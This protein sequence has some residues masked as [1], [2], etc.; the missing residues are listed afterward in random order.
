M[1]ILKYQWVRVASLDRLLLGLADNRNPA[2]TG[3]LVLPI[4]RYDISDSMFVE[5]V[6][7]S[8]TLELE[9]TIFVPKGEVIAILKTSDPQDLQRLG[10][11]GRGSAEP[12]AANL[13]AET[14]PPEV[15]HAIT[16]PTTD[17][18]PDHQPSI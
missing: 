10:Y 14:L 8:A 17:P 7:S 3:T 16:H 13:T 6:F 1:A 2:L 15:S 4:T 9:G 12:A 18:I 5:L 11:R